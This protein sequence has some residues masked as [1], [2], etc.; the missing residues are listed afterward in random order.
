VKTLPSP[1]IAITPATT[2]MSR[3]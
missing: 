1:I 2:G 3:A